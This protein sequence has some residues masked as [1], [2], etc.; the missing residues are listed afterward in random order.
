MFEQIILT[1]YENA[2]RFK[3]KQEDQFLSFQK[4]FDLWRESSEFTCFYVSLLE[5]G[6]Y[7][8]LFWEH[9][10]LTLIDLNQDY[11][12]IIY[13]THAFDKKSVDEDAFKDFI[14]SN[15]LITSFPNLGKNAML[16]APTKQNE[17]ACYK[18][19]GIFLQQAGKEQILAL[20]QEI[21]KLTLEQINEKEQ[22]WLNTSGMGVFWLHIRL[23]T[24]PKYYKTKRYKEIKYFVK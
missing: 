24:I 22:I 1:Q 4:V 14:S 21:G 2:I 12:C 8:G 13:R 20:F 19:F 7:S 6:E 15:H 18:H 11:E 17:A 23:D 9:P 16:I 3:L 10:P 5:E